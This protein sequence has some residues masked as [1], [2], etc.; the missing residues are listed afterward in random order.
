MTSAVEPGPRIGIIGAGAIG[1]FYGLMLARPAATG[2]ADT[3]K[4]QQR[5]TRQRQQLL[6]DIQIRQ[7]KRFHSIRTTTFNQATHYQATRQHAQLP[8]VEQACTR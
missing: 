3:G 2:T 8:I 7:F 4:H 1:G 5:S 6:V